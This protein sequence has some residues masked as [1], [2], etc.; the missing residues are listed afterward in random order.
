MTETMSTPETF[1]EEILL[2]LTPDLKR[3][4]QEFADVQDWHVTAAIRYF[5]KDGLG[6]HARRV[7][8]AQ[9]AADCWPPRNK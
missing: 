4:I 5:I 9:E 6:G 3:R 2:T 7:A 1:T 8:L